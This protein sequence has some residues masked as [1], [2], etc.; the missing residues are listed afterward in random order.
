MAVGS[1]VLA[2]PGNGED[3]LARVEQRRLALAGRDRGCKSSLGQFFTPMPT[4]RLMAEMS[5]LHRDYLRLL[6]A[7]AG[8]GSLTAAWVATLSQRRETPKRVSL[9]AYEIDETLH[10]YLRDTLAECQAAC[11]ERGIAC[12]WTIHGEDFIEAMVTALQGGLFQNARPA[13]DVAILNPPYKKFRTESRTRALLRRLGIETSNLYAAFLALTVEGLARGGEVIA[14]TPRS[15]CNGPYFRPFREHLLDR[16]SLTR[17]HTFSSRDHAFRDDEVLQENVIFHA[18]RMQ[19]QQATVLLT[20]SR[21][22]DEAPTRAAEVEFDQSN[23]AASRQHRFVSV[24]ER[25][26]ASAIGNDENLEQGQ[27][28]S[29]D[30][31][32]PLVRL[33]QEWGDQR[34]KRG[35]LLDNVD[36]CDGIEGDPA[37][38]DRGHQSAYRA[39]NRRRGRTRSRRGG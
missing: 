21:G 27:G 22:A 31:P 18:M 19:R 13:F 2:Q 4:A 5:T 34:K 36:E 14:I 39:A 1:T 24:G 35:V 7:G 15:F 11:A 20:E 12:D 33:R 25:E 23:A 10:A 17:I 6:D 9:T 29:H 16:I 26:V 30:F 37:G 3:L 28:R 8:I 32:P 38:A